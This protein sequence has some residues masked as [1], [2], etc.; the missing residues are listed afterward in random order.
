MH[1]NPIIVLFDVCIIFTFRSIA[2]E[3]FVLYL[4]PAADQSS[5]QLDCD[6]S[7]DTVPKQMIGRDDEDDTLLKQ[8]IG[9]SDDTVLKQP[10]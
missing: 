6:I 9:Q 4:E 3:R 8:P 5:D 10:V 1:A 7:D 2:C